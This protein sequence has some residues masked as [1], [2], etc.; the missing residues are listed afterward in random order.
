MTGEQIFMLVIV[1]IV[2]ITVVV[3]QF[4]KFRFR[5][6]PGV[7][8]WFSNRPAGGQHRSSN[9]DQAASARVAHELSPEES[10]A[11]L[12]RV[13][14]LIEDR[15]QIARDT[16]ISHHLWGLYRGLVRQN[17][18]G[19]PDHLIQD[20]EWYDV[21][22]LRV[23]TANGL[24]KI[25]F[26]LKGAKYIF[27]DD[28]EQQSWRVNLKLFNLFL[29]DEE[30]RCLIEIPMKT[31]V[32]GLGRKYSIATAGPRAFLSGNWINDFI[33][34]KLKHQRIRNQE[35]RTQKHQERLSEIEELKDR[36]GITD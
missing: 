35:I 28:E 18:P 10:E 15:K 3:L 23:S 32:D 7:L 25:E 4:S 11:E 12:L 16:D 33:Y 9:T 29:Y 36:F 2:V 17:D 1:V 20:G 22:I 31:A 14:Q 13:Q 30:G 21:K 34:V 27:V 26:E 8:N 24:N 19:S 5:I 6:K